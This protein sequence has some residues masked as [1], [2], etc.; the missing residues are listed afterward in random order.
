MQLNNDNVSELS[1]DINGIPVS[2]K[3]VRPWNYIS[4]E[5][6]SE[7]AKLMY[8]N[9]NLQSSLMTMQHAVLIIE[10]LNNCGYNVY[11]D[12]TSWGN[13]SN[14]SFKVNGLYSVDYGRTYTYSNNYIKGEYNTI[15]SS[16]A[17]DR[18]MA[19]NIFDF[20]GNLW[21]YTDTQLQNTE[22]HYSY[23]GYYATP[24]NSHAAAFTDAYTN[25]PS[26]KVGF[27]IYLKIN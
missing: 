26:S 8:N 19:N 25:E 2:K 1:N 11:E 14:T 20:A 24:G 9:E 10:W 7:N 4:Y 22:Y 16:G 23:G 27:R 13:Y 18:N 5:K 15:T 12:S 21:E 3:N 6:A 17:S